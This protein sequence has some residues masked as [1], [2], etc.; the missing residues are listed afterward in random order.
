MSRKIRPH[1]DEDYVAMHAA[2]LR[3]NPNDN[4]VGGPIFLL[5]SLINISNSNFT[6]CLSTVKE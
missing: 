6:S 4:L 1:S 2:C 3:N 5:F